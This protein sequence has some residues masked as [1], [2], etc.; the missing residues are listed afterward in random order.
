MAQTESCEDDE[1]STE[2]HP[3]N[4]EW[5]LDSGCSNHMTGDRRQF[6]KLIEQKGG[7]VIFG[8]N[9]RRQ[10][11]GK[12]T[13]GNVSDPTFHNVLLVEHLKLNLLS[14]SQLC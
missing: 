14:I 13:V 8:D 1:T 10:I 11:I 6:S 9:N 12:G 4:H 5:F 2:E 7:N 3:I